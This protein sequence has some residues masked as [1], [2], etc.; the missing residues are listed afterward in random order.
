MIIRKF[1]DCDVEEMAELF[2]NTVHSINAKDYNEAQLD[3]WADGKIDLNKWIE[4]YNR[5]YCLVVMIDNKIVGFGSI[6]GDYLDMLYVHKDYQG[7]RIA[8]KIV[9]KL[10]EQARKEHAFITTHSSITALPFFA[11]RGYSI[12]K[13]QQV[14]KSGVSLTNY[15]MINKF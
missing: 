9:D 14:I 6:E 12:I 10:E 13:E 3:V 15:I 11:K 5:Q 1:S 7:Q 4:R 8:T 2:Y